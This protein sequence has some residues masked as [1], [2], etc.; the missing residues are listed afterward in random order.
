MKTA[1]FLVA[2]AALNVAGCSV[3]VGGGVSDSCEDD[4]D[5][6]D[7]GFSGASCDLTK[8]Q[9]VVSGGGAACETADECVSQNGGKPSICSSEKKCVQLTSA[10]CAE[11]FGDYK[12]PDAIILGYLGP[13]VGGDASSGVPIDHGARLAL[14]EIKQS[15]VGLPGPNNTTRPLAMVF[16]NDANGANDGDRAAKH[17][18]NDVKVPAIVGPA[19]S[20]DTIRIAKDVTIPAGVLLMATSATSTQITDLADSGLVWRTCPSDALQAIPFAALV[21]PLEEAIRT[22]QMLMPAD[23]IR[24]TMT[25]KGD[26]YGTGL[27]D[28]V[29]P[30]LSFNGKSAADND[31]NF[32]RI[33]YEDSADVDYTTVVSQVVDKNK[34]P[35]I[36]MLF[37]TTEIV[38][39][40]LTGIEDAWDSLNPQPP[41]PYYLMPD[42]GKVDELIEAIGGDDGLRKRIRGT[43][44]AVG[45]ALYDGFSLRY[46][47]YFASD[48]EYSEPGAYAENGYDA[49]YLLAYAILAIGDK[50]VS[51]AN[52]N[53]GLKKMS[54]GTSI[55][56]GST[57][58][59]K[60]FSALQSTQEID[61]NGASGPLNFDPKTGEAR[62]DIEVWCV[63]RDEEMNAGFE[64]SGQEYDAVK[65]EIVGN[66]NDKMQCD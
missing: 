42:G 24:I 52:I 41:R 8:K 53:D 3:I 20:G 63:G 33:A 22:D 62:T 47:A 11:V 43:A 66:Y 7:L 58:I 49:A 18:A 60:A 48:P 50:P 39:N 4:S 25:V 54:K 26:A 19:F 15:V 46:K 34:P 28:A 36:V 56:A 37:G 16:C 6:A 23:Q 40:L 38:T 35:H 12:K 27:A 13:L 5:C 9:C 17:L 59:N 64:S 14:N 2:L 29:T 45:G 1:L 30:Q 65:D 31:T 55:N 61:F 51:G 44:P 32:R 21:G 57:D 10:D